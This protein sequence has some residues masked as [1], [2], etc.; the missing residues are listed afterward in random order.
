M[1][2]IH[3]CNGA[4]AAVAAA[5]AQEQT[6]KN[7]KIKIHVAQHDHCMHIHGIKN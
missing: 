1:K 5:V 4:T 2:Q 3:L 6:H 7:K